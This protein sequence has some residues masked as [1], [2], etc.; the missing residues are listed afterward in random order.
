M[1]KLSLIEWLILDDIGIVLK[2]LQ[3]KQN[4]TAWPP[5]QNTHDRI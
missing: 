3:W 1:E 5:L 2:E 4:W